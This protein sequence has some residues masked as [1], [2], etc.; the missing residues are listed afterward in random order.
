MLRKSHTTRNT[1]Q[2]GICGDRFMLRELKRFF[3]RGVANLDS[4]LTNA[5]TSPSQRNQASTVSQMR[6]KLNGT[7]KALSGTPATYSSRPEI[8]VGMIGPV[9]VDIDSITK[10]VSETLHDFW[11]NT[12]TIRVS[13]LLEQIDKLETDFRD[14]SE[15][16]RIK[17]RMEA[18]TKLRQK[19]KRGDI[20]AL[21]SIREI[22][23]ARQEN[24]PENQLKEG[25]DPIEAPLYGWA[26]IIR[27]IKHPDEAK[28][29]R[30]IYGNAFI[31]ISIYSPK[32]VRRANLIQKM[33]VSAK[34]QDEGPESLASDLLEIDEK[35]D[36]LEDLGQ[37]V[38]GAFPH[39]DIFVDSRDLNKVEKDLNR[40]FNSYF[41]YP[42]NTPTRDEFGMFTAKCA[43]YRSSDMSRQV[44]ACITN[45]EGSVLGI[46]NN[47]IPKA[48]G[49][50]Y[51][52]DDDPDGRDFVKGQDASVNF[53][54]KILTEIVHELHKQDILNPKWGDPQNL[55]EYFSSDSEG[56]KIWGRLLVSSLIE[57]GRPLHAEMAAILDAQSKGISIKDST[58]YCT[59]FPCHLC[60]RMI[61]GSGIKRVVFV[62]PYHKSQSEALYGDSIN[63]DRTSDDSTKVTFEPFVGVSPT[64]YERLFAY[65]GKRRD[66][67]GKPTSWSK[68]DPEPLIKRFVNTYPMVEAIAYSETAL[69]R[70]EKVGLKFSA[71]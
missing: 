34:H 49:G 38:S 10:K 12:N 63:V 61:I 43:S 55:F 59:T 44:G 4:G 7:K 22:W 71:G 68:N 15:Y 8:V 18:G 60:A 50:L 31:L 21:L 26:H 29:L 56:K 41:G 40:F 36:D 20:L 39:A 11:Y 58:L 32:E 65:P 48:G 23:R 3:S 9:G 52:E 1:N 27:S 67:D 70:L 37:D 2:N 28:A 17:S 42:F 46:G 19:V 14:G 30:E 24:I 35:E 47:E 62:E 25:L 57:F 33:T 66:S 45:D 16:E 6:D 13:N 69:P 5:I 51:W 64:K 54:N 53:R